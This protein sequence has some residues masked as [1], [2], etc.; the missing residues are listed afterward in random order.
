M[1]RRGELGDVEMGR[2]EL[3]LQQYSERG[4]VCELEVSFPLLGT[5]SGAEAM[6]GWHGKVGGFR[7]MPGSLHS[8]RTW[9]RWLRGEVARARTATVESFCIPVGGR[10]VARE[11]QGTW[12]GVPLSLGSWS[13]VTRC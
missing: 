7:R 5:R 8:H 2:V 3:E 4:S 11:V 6:H 1:R 9:A 10:P 12:L 13:C